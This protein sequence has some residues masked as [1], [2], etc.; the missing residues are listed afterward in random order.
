[1]MR[2]CVCFSILLV[3]FGIAVPRSFAQKAARMPVIIE[4]FTSEGCDTCPPADKYLQRLLQDQPIDGVE[5]IALA[6]HVDYWDRLGWSDPFSSSLFSKRQNYYADFFKHDSVYT[7][8]MIVNGTRELRGKDGNKPIEDAAKDRIGIIKLTISKAVEGTVSLKVKV[9]K[10]PA[11]SSGD[12]AIV[13]LAVTEDELTSNVLRG[14]NSGR[15]LKHM[16]VARILRTIGEVRGE[17]TILSAD[18]TLEKDWKRD[19]LSVVAFVQEVG[20]RRIL[21][22]VKIGIKD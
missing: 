21:G 8:Q 11:I 18:L 2:T 19:D 3:A 20:S 4:L 17:E 6:E 22:A 9:T 5:I 1:M 13:F 10:L 14:E 15:K 7:P 12:Q 16:A